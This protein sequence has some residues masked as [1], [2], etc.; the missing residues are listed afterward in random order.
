MLNPRYPL[1]NIDKRLGRDQKEPQIKYH[2]FLMEALEDYFKVR[3]AINRPFYTVPKATTDPNRPFSGG[4]W[5]P[6]AKSFEL[7][8]VVC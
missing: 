2:N 5:L 1:T 4:C 6:Y 3:E 8:R 7:E